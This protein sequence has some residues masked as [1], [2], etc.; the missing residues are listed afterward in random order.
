MGTHE[1]MPTVVKRPCL[2]HMSHVQNDRD[3]SFA[4][5]PRNW[6]Y[7]QISSAHTVKVMFNLP[8]PP[9]H[10]PSE[11]L[12]RGGLER[13]RPCSR[14]ERRRPICRQGGHLWRAQ[15]VRRQR[16]LWGLLQRTGEH[17]DTGT[18]TVGG[19]ACDTMCTGAQLLFLWI[20][21][22]SGETLLMQNFYSTTINQ[23]G[24]AD[25]F[26]DYDFFVSEK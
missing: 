20:I 6:L 26:C 18:W 11:Q 13:G 9:P 17:H 22:K 7:C 21:I 3:T 15:D 24:A 16:R 14:H 19:G 1:L 8:Y 5:I 23:Q 10:F 25:W 12:Q 2:K 4:V